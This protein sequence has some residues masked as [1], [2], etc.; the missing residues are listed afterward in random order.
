MLPRRL[1]HQALFLSTLTCT[2]LSKLL[3]N[4]DISTILVPMVSVEKWRHR[5]GQ[6]LAWDHLLPPW[7]NQ[8]PSPGSREAVRSAVIAG[9]AAV[10]ACSRL[11]HN[12]H[13]H[14]RLSLGPPGLLLVPWLSSRFF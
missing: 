10:L 11:N 9:L 6:S 1:P 13:L 12:T 14:F 3:T 4:S 8:D 5:K 2:E 7:E